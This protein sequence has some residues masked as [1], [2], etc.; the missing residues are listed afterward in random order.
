MSLFL[1]LK[2]KAPGL[3]ILYLADTARFPYGS[4]DQKTLLRYAEEMARFLIDQ[5]VSTIL[6]GCNAASSASLPQLQEK[7]SFPI[8]GVIDP[9]VQYI[10]RSFSLKKLGIIGTQATIQIGKHKDMLAASRPDLQII[11][12]ACPKLAPA[13]ESGL[14]HKTDVSSLIKEYLTPLLDEKIDS[15]LLACTH[16]SFLKSYLTS[17]LPKDVPIIDPAEHCI[18]SLLQGITV[19]GTSSTCRFFTTKD[20]SH[21]KQ[22]LKKVLRYTPD[23]VEIIPKKYVQ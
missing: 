10:T 1:E 15:L 21:F 8:I 9:A 11:P 16:Y 19:K 14:I 17:Y 2:K 23:S 22:A 4:K 18:D 12:Q 5:G 20:P 13:V 6:F 3:P 7:L